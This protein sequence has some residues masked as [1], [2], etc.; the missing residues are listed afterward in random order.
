MKAE[1]SGPAGRDRAVTRLILPTVFVLLWSTG[2]VFA[3]LGLPYVGPFTFLEI[4][5]VVVISLLTLL[6]LAT[7]APWPTR[8]KILPISI[9]G[10]LVHAGYL[11]GVFAAISV[12]VEAGVAALVAGL[13]PVLTA[14]LAGPLLGEKVSPLQWL[15]LAIGFA[16]VI[17]V[18][19]TKLGLGLGTPLGMGL[20]A[21]AMFS[22]T[23][24][25]LW[26]K[27]FCG[28]MDLRTGSVV[29]FAASAV[30]TLPLAWGL[31]GLRVD[32]TPNLV[33]A[34]AWLCLVLSI[35][36]ITAMFV[37]IRRGKASEVSSLFFL[38][39]P[40]TAVI[41]WVMFHETL[42]PLSFVGMALVVFAVAMVT[43]RSGR[44]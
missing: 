12:G 33:I 21:F 34:L 19:H 6:S 32:W 41:A 9:G 5:Y 38:V 7:S 15:G 35:G 43:W 42:E 4:R 44:A 40:T 2:F 3:K 23:A 28:G 18:V 17:L 1:L 11:G 37:L 22:I 25:T 20:S 13:Q 29:Q 26:Q 10:L 39:P 27:R 8:D 30:V 31:E 24:G 16:G 14:A 36:A